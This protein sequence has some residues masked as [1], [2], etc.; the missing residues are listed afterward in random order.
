MPVENMFLWSSAWNTTPALVIILQVRLQGGGGGST[1]EAGGIYLFLSVC[2]MLR[3]FLKWCLAFTPVGLNNKTADWFVSF[4]A[5]LCDGVK[6]KSVDQNIYNPMKCPCF[7]VTA[8]WR[9]QDSSVLLLA[10]LLHPSPT[11]LLQFHIILLRDT[12]KT[13][14]L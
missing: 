12:S 14:P 7:S 3:L 8:F 13:S 10:L 6:M 11:S 9:M 5:G 4:C 1:L 2:Q